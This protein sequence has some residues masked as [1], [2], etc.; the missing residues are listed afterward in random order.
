MLAGPLIEGWQVALS[1]QRWMK[2]Q[3]GLRLMQK[4]KQEETRNKE[5]LL[6]FLEHDTPN[7][8]PKQQIQQ[9]SPIISEA[10]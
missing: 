10:E 1:L 2:R 5:C 8:V 4:R 3:R 9:P 7:T 6:R